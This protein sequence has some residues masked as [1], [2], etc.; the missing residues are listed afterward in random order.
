MRI[1]TRLNSSFEAKVLTAF[2]AA[3]LVVTALVAATWRVAN[4]ALEATHQVTY[5][6]A[7]LDNL[8]RARI[9]TLQ[10]EFSTQSF[11]ISGDP[12]RLTER[13]AAISSR[14]AALQGVKQLTSYNAAQQERW[15]RLR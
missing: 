6:R 1:S 11:R 10:I 2:T 15:T 14:E 13:D 12:A 9:D 4:D 8:A 7:V 3:A 5:T